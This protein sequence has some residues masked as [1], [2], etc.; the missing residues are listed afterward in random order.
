MEACYSCYAIHLSPLAFAM[1]LYKQMYILTW[2]TLSIHVWPSTLAPSGCVLTMI[3][4]KVM[5][6]AP[7]VFVS[8][9]AVLVMVKVIVIMTMTVIRRLSAHTTGD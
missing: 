6:M 4:V 2:Q 8:D 3:V 9:T 5:A 1:Q 7:I